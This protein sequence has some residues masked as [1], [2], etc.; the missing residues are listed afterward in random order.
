VATYNVIL[1]ILLAVPQL[2]IYFLTKQNE[3]TVLKWTR[4]GYSELKTVHNLAGKEQ[5]QVNFQSQNSLF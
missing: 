5:N 1:S 4:K 2:K 3:S